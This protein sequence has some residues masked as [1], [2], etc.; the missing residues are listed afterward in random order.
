M[1]EETKKKS[2]HFNI[3]IIAFLMIFIYIIGHLILSVSKEEL[4]VYQVVQSQIH[5]SIRGTGIIL[6]DETIVKCENAGYLNY[7]VNDGEIVAKHGLV[8]TCDRTGEAH[9]YI[10]HFLEQ[11][12]KLTASD[13]SEIKDLLENFEENYKDSDFSYVYDLKYQLENQALKLG[14]AAMADYMDE[15][16]AE[17]G[18]G[19]FVKSYSKSQGIVTY[20]QDGY[21][22]M[23]LEELTPE[24][25]N[26][27]VYEKKNL[28][29]A[30]AVGEGDSV[31]RLTK[32]TDWNIVISITAKEYAKIKD[33][34]KVTVHLHD[35][36]FT[37]TCPVEFIHQS[38]QYYAVLTM[39]N[40][41]P[42][43][44]NDRYVDVEVEV[45]A[46]DGLK[47]PNT[48]I[49]EKEFY[50]I[51]KAYL[52][53][54]YSAR[55]TMVIKSQDS[56]GNVTF[57]TMD[58]DIGKEGKDSEDGKEYY[59][60]LKEDVPEHALISMADSSETM[61][62]KDTVSLP[63]VYVINRGYADFTCVDILLENKD[64]TIVRSNMKNSIEQFD[65]IIL[66]G[67]TTENNAIIY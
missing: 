64:Y 56:K 25:F 52:T 31:Y 58:V 21:E 20:V 38:G 13:Y 8:Y 45:R 60:I 54:R 47:I 63:G 51:P 55:K 39:T 24:S 16:E 35:D 7:Y 19:S 28:K 9:E 32:N 62:L 40:Y 30:D 17:L 18:S 6:R 67:S 37:V 61:L 59:Y 34:S 41:L 12:N 43:F 10:S 2:F 1:A 3:G 29:T 33:R 57:Q 44:V 48:S 66:N 27:T 36:E 46:E 22:G 50:K 11:K 4:A 15:I 14:D 49:V 53:G 42:H 65:R 26:T 23:T 5:E